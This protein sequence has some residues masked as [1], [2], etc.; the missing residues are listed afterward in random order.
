MLYQVLYLF[1]KYKDLLWFK[2]IVIL[3]WALVLFLSISFHYGAILCARD[4][5]FGVQLLNQWCPFG[6]TQLAESVLTADLSNSLSSL[7]V[8]WWYLTITMG[9]FTRWTRQMISMAMS[10]SCN[11]TPDSWAAVIGPSSHSSLISVK[12]NVIFSD[13]IVLNRQ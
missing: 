11:S 10:I 9:L 2:A 5:F 4:W 7:G 8:N 3:L 1:L 13:T 12:G 6:V